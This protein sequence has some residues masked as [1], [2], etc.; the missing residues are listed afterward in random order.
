MKFVKFFSII[1]MASVMMSCLGDSESTTKED[2]TGYCFNYVTDLST[3]TSDMTWGGSYILETNYTD[4]VA[5]L[6]IN[7]LKLSSTQTVSLSFSNMKYSINEKGGFV[8]KAPS[9]VSSYN[10]QHHTITDFSLELYRRNIGSSYL[11]VM[12]LKF[13][14]DSQYQVRVVYAPTTYVGSTVVTDAEG[15]AYTTSQPYYAVIF[16]P[17]K[18][19][20]SFYIMGAK[21]AEMMPSMDMVFP[22]V[23]FVMN[24]TGFSLDKDELTPNIGN[25]PYKDFKITGLDV[26]AFFEGGMRV[27]FKCT[28]DTK[29][30]KG[31]YTVTASLDAL[32]VATSQQDQQ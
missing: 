28:I 6:T 14:V 31:E 22:D 17:T 13:T 32:G 2:F 1:A 20:A 5:T 7:N 3:G 9:Y 23:P 8:L 30:M 25:V 11:P 18:S 21:F 19:K 24:Q 15:K 29:S 12:W 16:D 27:K 4:G 10:A 26:E